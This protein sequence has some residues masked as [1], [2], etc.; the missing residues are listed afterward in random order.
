MFFE[1]VTTV[2]KLNKE[3]EKMEY[4]QKSILK[5]SD[6]ISEIIGTGTMS[7]II[8]YTYCIVPSALCLPRNVQHM[9]RRLILYGIH[10]LHHKGLR[11]Y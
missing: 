6:G 8:L 4:I 3:L 1:Y 7:I 11:S 2:L 5:L 10:S 9:F